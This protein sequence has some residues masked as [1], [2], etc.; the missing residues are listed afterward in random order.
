[1][2]EKKGFFAGTHSSALNKFSDRLDTMHS[3]N[4]FEMTRND[5][6]RTI[7]KSMA[8][9]PDQWDKYCE[10][11]INLIGDSF[12]NR[13]SE[14]NE[15]LTKEKIDKIFSLCFRYL[16][17]YYLSIQGKFVAELEEAREFAFD[18]LDSF[19]QHAK[20]QIKYA[21]LQM[22]IAIFK[23]IANNESIQNLKDFNELSKLAD[24]KRDE[25]EQDLSKRE[26]RVNTL[27]DAL[28]TYESGFNFVGLFDGFNDLSKEKNIEKRNLLFW[29][30]VLGFLIVT[31]LIAKIVV[32]YLNLENLENVKD[33]LALSIVPTISVVA[34][35]V[36]YFRVILFNYKAVNSQ[37]LQI[38][39]RKTLCRFIQHYSEYASKIKGKDSKSLEKFENIIFSGIISDDKNLPTTF[40]GMT[41]LGNLIKSVKS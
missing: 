12:I 21:I 28:S 24:T 35:F 6:L 14:D 36:Y 29:L 9:Y 26:S 19:E 20:E 38:E 8:S 30:K 16:F 27:K 2:E 34:I 13:I 31:P 7:I 3:E 25:W 32:L 22:P 37:L 17:E 18:S 1:M 15:N 4:G 23:S 11:N 41:E 39:L 33:I 10:I 5:H 40:D